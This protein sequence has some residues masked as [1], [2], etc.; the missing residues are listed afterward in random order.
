MITG[1]IKQKVDDVWQTFW[2]NGFTQ[3]SAIFEQINYQCVFGICVN[4]EVG[5]YFWWGWR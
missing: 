2:N 3:P 4:Y 1:D 5:D